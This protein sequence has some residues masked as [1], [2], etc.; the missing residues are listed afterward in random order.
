[1][2]CIH[3]RHANMLPYL[4]GMLMLMLMLRSCSR[5]H[6]ENS[7]TVSGSQQ[8]VRCLAPSEAVATV[9]TKK[10]PE[11]ETQLPRMAKLI[12]IRDAVD[13]LRSRQAK[14]ARCQGRATT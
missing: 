8:D 14:C 9:P 6:Y 5:Y 10:L 2:M 12:K 7:L 4:G 1:M 3:M 11:D 13:A